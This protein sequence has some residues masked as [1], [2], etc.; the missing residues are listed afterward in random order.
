MVRRLKLL[1]V[2]MKS[3]CLILFV[4]TSLF[5]SAKSGNKTSMQ[6]VVLNESGQP[7]KAAVVY[8]QPMDRKL[9]GMIPHTST[10]EQGS[11]VLMD[12]PSG[13]YQ[14]Y[15]EKDEEDY[16]NLGFDFYN[17]G[18]KQ[19]VQ[20]KAN[21]DLPALTLLVGPKAGV[22]VGKVTDSVTGLSLQPCVRFH[23][24]EDARML[25]NGSG[26]VRGS[27]RLLVPADTDVSFGFYL[28]GYRPWFYP[29]TADQESGSPIRLPAGQEMQLNVV[30]QPLDSGKSYGC[31]A[32]Q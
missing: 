28:D 14:V 16:P 5:V 10:D 1:E 27:F 24:M 3:L 30:M 13:R 15:A 17:G 8:A 12:L 11:F 23:R 31:P 9:G 18:Q 26:L 29:G 6:G 21:E 2:R 22:L 25:M 20:V 4:A 19:V 32:V 7:V